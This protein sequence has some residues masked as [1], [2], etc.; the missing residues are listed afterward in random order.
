MLSQSKKQPKNPKIFHNFAS[1]P[2]YP[3]TPLKHQNHGHNHAKNQSE[4]CERSILQGVEGQ[5]RQYRASGDKGGGHQTRRGLIFRGSILEHHRLV[6]LAEEATGGDY[7][8]SRIGFIQNA[9]FQHLLVPGYAIGEAVSIGYQ[10]T[11][12]RLSA[13]TGRRGFVH[14]RF[15]IRSMR[16]G[17]RR[18]SILRRDSR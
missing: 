10:T 5:R 3:E 16:G 8:A 12:R 6:G 1:I 9:C 18:Q 7:G 11:C 4:R 14:G 13:K 15:S 17:G 2:T